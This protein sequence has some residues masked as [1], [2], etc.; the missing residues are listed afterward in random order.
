VRISFG[1]V[2]ANYCGQAPYFSK[3]YGKDRV[4]G[5]EADYLI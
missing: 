3:L 2:T 5:V 4:K 1:R